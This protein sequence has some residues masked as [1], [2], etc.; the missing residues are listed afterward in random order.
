MI[1]GSAAVRVVTCASMGSEI[2]GPA[3]PE[4]VPPSEARSKQLN[5]ACLE[6]ARFS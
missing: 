2:H 4:Q 3:Q 6:H 5:W 1:C